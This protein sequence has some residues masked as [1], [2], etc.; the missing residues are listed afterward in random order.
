MSVKKNSSEPF[1]QGHPVRFAH[2]TLRFSAEDGLRYSPRLVRRGQLKTN[3]YLPGR[4]EEADIHVGLLVKIKGF[5]S[6]GS[7]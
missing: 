3:R 1:P 7:K 6:R 5:Q 4:A 2:R